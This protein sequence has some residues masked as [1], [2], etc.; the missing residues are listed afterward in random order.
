MKKAD[1]LVWFGHN[2][3]VLPLLK[4]YENMG[5]KMPLSLPLTSPAQEVILAE[6][7]NVSLGMIGSE[8]YTSLFDTK[9]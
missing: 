1:C 2:P 6:A 5:L 9:I 7:G 4:Q 8:W 3:A